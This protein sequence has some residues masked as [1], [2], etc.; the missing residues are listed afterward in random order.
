MPAPPPPRQPLRLSPSRQS[1]AAS[2]P[3]PAVPRPPGP[4][5]MSRTTGASPHPPSRA[6]RAG[7][8]PAALEGPPVPGAHSAPG[9]GEP[10]VRAGRGSGTSTSRMQLSHAQRW[11]H[12]TAPWVQCAGWASV[13]QQIGPLPHTRVPPVFARLMYLR[14][15]PLSPKLTQPKVTGLSMH[16]ATPCPLSSCSIQSHRPPKHRT[17]T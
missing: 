9:G 5:P 8:G 16:L 3:V 1:P 13:V 11:V 10:S 4:N 12:C 2:R 17:S 6:A 7:D 15:P 14:S